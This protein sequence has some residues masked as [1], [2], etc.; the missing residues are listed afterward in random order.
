[1]VQRQLEGKSYLRDEENFRIGVAAA[2]KSPALSKSC[3]TN[4][5]RPAILSSDARYFDDASGKTYL[6]Y[7]RCCYKHA[8][9]SEVSTWAKEKGWFDEIEESWI[10]GVELKP[11][12]SGI[13]ENR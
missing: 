7:S 12:F 9:D 4:W 6:Y 11:D 13:I 3:S 10:Y 5:A 1:M 8:V 2:D